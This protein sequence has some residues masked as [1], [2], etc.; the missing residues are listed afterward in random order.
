MC[1]NKTQ[2]KHPLLGYVNLGCILSVVEPVKMRMGLP[3]PSKLFPC[4]FCHSLHTY[5]KGP[6]RNSWYFALS[7]HL[8]HSYAS[9]DVSNL[10]VIF[11]LKDISTLS[12]NG[13]YFSNGFNVYFSVFNTCFQHFIC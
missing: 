5:R 9:S 3:R 8:A 11:D 13:Q 2:F 10:M 7:S 4:C 1:E 12:F 6:H